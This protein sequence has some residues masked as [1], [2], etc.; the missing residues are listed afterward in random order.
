MFFS[1]PLYTI[2]NDLHEIHR[3]MQPSD[4]PHLTVLSVN[5]FMDPFTLFFTISFYQKV[6]LMDYIN[7]YHRLNFRYFYGSIFV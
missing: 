6:D 1:V 7:D 3:G 2:R 4:R 5:D